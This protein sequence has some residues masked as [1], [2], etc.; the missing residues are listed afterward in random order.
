[1]R[2]RMMW[3][4][5]AVLVVGIASG[6]AGCA[7]GGRTFGNEMS[8]ADVHNIKKGRTTES[9][10]LARFGSPYRTLSLGNGEKHLSYMYSDSS[11]AIKP[12]SYIPIVGHF[13]GGADIKSKTQ[14]LTVIIGSNGVVKDYT[15]VDSTSDSALR[16]R[17]PG[18]ISITPT[19]STTVR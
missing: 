8:S 7:M 14:S 3:V 2:V 15:Y 17:G 12:Q 9:E 10:I 5:V 19:S 16:M 6:L 4:V 1:M 18:N 11:T 13:A